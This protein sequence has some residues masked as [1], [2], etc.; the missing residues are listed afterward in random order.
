MKAINIFIGPS[1]YDLNVDFFKASN[2]VIHPPVKKH[3]IDNLVAS[4]AERGII[5][6]ID[7]TFF[8]YP[9]V[10][11]VEIREAIAKGWEIWGLSSMGAIRAYEMRNDG[12]KGFGY[13]YS[14]FF[15]EEDFKD[16]EMA[17]LYNPI[18]PY[19]PITEPLINIRNF[20]AQLVKTNQITDSIC[21]KILNTFSN[22]WFGKRTLDMLETML[23]ENSCMPHVFTELK[24]FKKY[25]IKTLDVIDFFKKKPW[26][27]V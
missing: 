16:D 2:Y 1:G 8:P 13:V 20:L 4:S 12:M 7:G 3:D 10:G 6:L 23:L 11:H 14:C 19:D 17:Q 15:K 26:D 27:L 22:L 25:R 5:V 21:N 18:F 24:N 9:A